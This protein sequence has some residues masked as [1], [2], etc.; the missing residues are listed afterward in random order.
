VN[1]GRTVSRAMLKAKARINKV[2]HHNKKLKEKMRITTVTTT[3]TK[4][5]E[6]LG[7]D[8][9]KK[10]FDVALW[11]EN[12]FRH[13]V[14]ANTEAG[15]A[16]L[17][18]WLN[19][20]LV[21]KVHGCMEATGTYWEALAEYLVAQGHQVSV[22]NAA[23]IK[24]YGKSLLR[25]NKTDKADAKLIALYGLNHQLRQWS[26][27]APQ[28]KQLQA[29]VRRLEVLQQMQQEE[30]N[31]LGSGVQQK[32]VLDSLQTNI[33]F[34][35]Q[36]IAQIKLLIKDEMDKNPDLKQQKQ[37]LI[38]IPGIG[39]TT[40][41]I[42]LAEIVNINNYNDARQVAA[43]AGLSPRHDDSG[44]REGKTRLCKLGNSRIRKALYFPAIVA[45][46]HNPII[47]DFCQRLAQRGKQGMLI[48]GA[49][50]RK[51]LHLAYG[52]LKSGKA[53]DPHHQAC[54]SHK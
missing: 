48:I 24:N 12:K 50:M 29:L 35:A 39:D 18:E 31:R 34:L 9:S 47:R 49:A 54:P 44:K 53:F 21:T 42:V 30:E 15:F 37:L 19:K 52:V 25:R 13:K 8:I 6:I 23:A 38:S 27:P 20:Q 3:T 17:Q 28:L 14:F 26:A 51:L 4:P 1:K 22:V 2:D 16:Q 32:D 36:Q 41:A 43:Y 40:A 7:I 11:H 10:K 33:K 5:I 45:K 46:Q